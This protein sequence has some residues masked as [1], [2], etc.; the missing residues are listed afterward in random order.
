MS[1]DL[2]IE[3]AVVACVLGAALLSLSAGVGLM[4]FRDP[5]A[6]L[7]AATKPQIFGLLLIIAA[8]ALEQRSLMTLFAL[9]PVFILQSLTAPVSAHMA[10]RAAYRAGQIDRDGLALDELDAVIQSANREVV[11]P[12]RTELSAEES[13]SLPRGAQPK[14]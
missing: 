4:R 7:H 10:G 11:D 9:L 12:Y 5:L 2:L 14:N 8:V 6:R 13:A 1:L 3:I